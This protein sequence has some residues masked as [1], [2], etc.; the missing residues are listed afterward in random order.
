MNRI[1]L[2]LK[3]G[4]TKQT[5][6]TDSHLCESFLQNGY[7]VI[8]MDNQVTGRAENLNKMFYDDAFTFYNHDVTEFINVSGDPARV[9]HL[10]S[11]ASPEFLLHFRSR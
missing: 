1:L 11:L 4:G 6:S 10:A 5:R 2:S 8:A 7:E 3:T 9:V